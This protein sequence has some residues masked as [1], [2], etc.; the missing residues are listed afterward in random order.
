MLHEYIHTISC[1]GLT[2]I[3][4]LHEYIHT[5]SCTGL[6]TIHNALYENNSNITDK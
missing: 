4:M 5:I 1:T 6:T 2:T 3:H